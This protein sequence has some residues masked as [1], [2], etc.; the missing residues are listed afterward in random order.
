MNEAA[1][2]P[3]GV[4]NPEVD[5]FDADADFELMSP[6]AE[7]EALAASVTVTERPERLDLK[8]IHE[9]PEVFQPRDR[10]SEQHIQE[11]V[12][13]IK[14]RGVL[15]PITVMQIGPKSFV[16]DGHHRRAAYEEAGKLDGIPVVYFEGTIRAAVLEAGEANSKAKLPMDNTTRQNFGWRLV[17]EGYSKREVMKSAAI[18][19]GQVS[20]MKR[21]QKALGPDA[22]NHEHWFLAMRAARKLEG[23]V[24]TEDDREGWKE[25]QALQYA[26]RMSKAFG[27]KLA[28]NT[29]VAAMALSIHFGRRLEDLVGILRHY[30]SEEAWNE[31]DEDENPDF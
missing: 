18:S 16:I 11:L 31:G 12:R 23:F 30:V 26:D 21:V 15:D 9:R 17:R 5:A 3:Q 20:N 6:R 29:E 2:E 28:N 8:D 13:A 19:R 7:L 22:A 24:E 1:A 14:S 10:V 25:A 27:T 4:S